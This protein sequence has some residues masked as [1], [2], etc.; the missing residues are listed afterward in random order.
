MAEAQL[1][2]GWTFESLRGL[3]HS[4]EG[5][6]SIQADVAFLWAFKLSRASPWGLMGWTGRQRWVSTK[7]R[8]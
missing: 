8:F 4:E 1:L 3:G 5:L 6:Q 7:H 2:A